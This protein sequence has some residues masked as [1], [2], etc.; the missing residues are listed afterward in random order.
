MNLQ[1]FQGDRDLV[2]EEIP[3]NEERAKIVQ[4]AQREK[5][6]PEDIDAAVEEADRQ[7]MLAQDIKEVLKTP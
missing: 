2:E 5:L 4:D 6:E 3:K 1:G 7:F